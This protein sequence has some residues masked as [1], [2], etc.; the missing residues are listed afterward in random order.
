MC[1]QNGMTSIVF[2]PDDREQQ[3][4]FG[5]AHGDQHLALQDCEI[6]AITVAVLW[7]VPPVSHAP[8]ISVRLRLN[9]GVGPSVDRN[10]FQ[11]CIQIHVQCANTFGLALTF[12]RIAYAVICPFDWRFRRIP[13]GEESG[14]RRSQISLCR[15][16]RRGDQQ[17]RRYQAKYRDGPHHV[18]PLSWD[19]QFAIKTSIRFEPQPS[20]VMKIVRM[21]W[22]DNCR[23]NT[24]ERSAAKN[25]R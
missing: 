19:H 9:R 4:L 24:G 13:D 11:P 20:N 15:Q 6:F 18:I 1:R 7:I 14:R 17:T 3:G 25:V 21:F 23:P 5:E 12:S 2:V 22:L 10:E 8:V 16:T